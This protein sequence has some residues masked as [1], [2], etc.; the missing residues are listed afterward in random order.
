VA[1]IV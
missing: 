1:F